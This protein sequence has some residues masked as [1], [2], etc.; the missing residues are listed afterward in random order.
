MCKKIILLSTSATDI[1]TNKPLVILAKCFDSIPVI[2]SQKYA[3]DICMKHLKI[4]SPGP[5]FSKTELHFPD[6][7]SEYLYI[8]YYLSSVQ[9]HC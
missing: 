6:M 7:A 9:N 8:V 4:Q 1:A 3:F 5:Y 2:P